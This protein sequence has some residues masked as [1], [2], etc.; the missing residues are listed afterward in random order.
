MSEKQNRNE[1]LCFFE[2]LQKYKIEIPI[3]QRDYAQG[4]IENK[5]IRKN[6]LDALKDS[7]AEEKPINLD[8]VYGNVFGDV[9]QPLDGQQRLTTLY[10]LHWY[11]F[12]K[13]CADDNSVKSTLLKFSYETRISSREFCHALISNPIIIDNNEDKISNIITDSEWFFMSW[14][15]DPTIR[16][17]LNTINDIHAIFH[18]VEGLWGRLTEKRLITFHLL[19]LEHF[20]LSDDLYIKMNA[21]GKLLTPF[22]NFKAELQKK[23]QENSWETQVEQTELFAHKIDTRWTD[24]LWSKFRRENAIDDAHMRFITAL[25]MIKLS[26][27][28]P[29]LRASERAEYLIKL[30]ESYVERNLVSLVTKETFDF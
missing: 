26:S 10:L 16:S 14:S 18:D 24:F 21:R 19:I 13:D 8:F 20:G 5:Q 2:V 22:E 30:N 28:Q 17:M 9:F 6:F 7:I 11:A 23:S 27:G 1:I 12:I 29:S 25:I 15:Q 3:I 4:R